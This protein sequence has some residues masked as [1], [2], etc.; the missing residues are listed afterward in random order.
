MMILMR[1]VCGALCLACMI[2]LI[3][4]HGFYG[5]EPD[6]QGIV[7]RRTGR[8]QNAAHGEGQIIVVSKANIGHAMTEYDGIA[9]LIR[10]IRRHPGA[11]HYICQRLKWFAVG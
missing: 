11:Q 7:D 9:N 4:M 2:R 8:G 10:Q 3:G 5:V 6:K 1:T